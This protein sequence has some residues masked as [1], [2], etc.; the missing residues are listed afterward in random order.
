MNKC[1]YNLKI[2]MKKRKHIQEILSEE[3][4]I[5]AKE[6]VRHDISPE[7]LN[8]LADEGM[9]ERLA[10]GVYASPD[11]EATEHFDLVIVQKRVPQGV[12]CL[13]TALSFHDLTTQIPS[14]VYLAVERGQHKP[15]LEWPPLNVFHISESQFDAGIEEY[16]LESGP[17]LRVYSPARTVADCFKFR[18]RIGL[19]VAI[20][21]L[22]DCWDQQQATVDE[23]MKYAEVCRVKNVIRPYLQ[24]IV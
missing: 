2:S 17:T 3:G 15:Q 6:L 13:L 24:A 12:F 14:D 9:V 19:D 8:H 7:Y 16:Q 20:E 18:N 1:K 4:V 11:Y 22:H 21:A 10:R 23:I 5:R